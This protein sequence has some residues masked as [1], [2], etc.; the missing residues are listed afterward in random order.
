MKDNINKDT[1]REYVEMK[2]KDKT[3]QIAALGLMASFSYKKG[4]LDTVKVCYDLINDLIMEVD[5]L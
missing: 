3:A 4:Y 5:L 1:L 2:S